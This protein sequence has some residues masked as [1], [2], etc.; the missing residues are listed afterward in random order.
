MACVIGR[1]IDRRAVCLR[2]H[3]RPSRRSD[4]PL[5][6][7]KDVIVPNDRAR[8]AGYFFTPWALVT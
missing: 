4:E 6:E 8:R 3:R 7:L 1:G 5:A 2:K